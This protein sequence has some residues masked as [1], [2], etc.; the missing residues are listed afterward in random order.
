M[1]QVSKNIIESMKTVPKL[2]KDKKKYL[3]GCNTKIYL[4]KYPNMHMLANFFYPS[5]IMQ[6]VD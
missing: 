3:Q 1:M 4:G 2:S 5:F 6:S